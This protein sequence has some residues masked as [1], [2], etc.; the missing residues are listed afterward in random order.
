MLV[1]NVTNK[2]VELTEL[3]SQVYT[4]VKSDDGM[5]ECYCSS[6]QEISNCTG[7]DTKVLRGVISSLVKKDVAYVDELVSGCG[8]FVILYEDREY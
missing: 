1:N 6:P 7:I 5:E 3:E 2:P 4:A 8:D